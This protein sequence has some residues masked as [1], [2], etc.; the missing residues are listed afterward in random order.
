MPRFSNLLESTHLPPGLHDECSAVDGPVCLG[1]GHPPLQVPVAGA[2][3]QVVP[4]VVAVHDVGEAEGL[5]LAFCVV[6]EH[7]NRQVTSSH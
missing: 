1:E 5:T 4:T 6:E 3:S 7:N 2:S